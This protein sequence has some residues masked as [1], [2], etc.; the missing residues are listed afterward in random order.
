MRACNAGARSVPNCL[1]R[2][3]GLWCIIG[4]MPL[5][6]LL[7]V[8]AAQLLDFGTFLRMVGRHGPESEANPLV[9]STFLGLGAPGVLLL[10]LLLVTVVAG[11]AAAGWL[12]PD[13]P[14]TRAAA[15]LTVG[16]AIVAGL[17]GAFSN[18]R[19]LLGV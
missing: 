13:R 12:R 1:F 11:I 8:L 9:A 2:I 14:A 18:T 10:K 3:G 5:A 7:T 15:A 19:V 17:A 4:A 16:A 6:A